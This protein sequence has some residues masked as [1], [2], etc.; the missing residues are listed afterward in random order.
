MDLIEAIRQRKSIRAFKPDPVSKEDIL[1]LISAAVAAPSKGNSQIWEFTVV[2]GDKKRE[3]DMML[4]DL[5]KTNPIPRMTLADSDN[6]G[7]NEM[8]RKVE[9]R[10]SR[11][12]AEIAKL[13]SPIGLSFEKFMLEGTFTFFNAPVAILIFMDEAFSKDLP[14]ILS[15]GASVQNILLAAMDKG[16]GT[17]WIGGVWRYTKE[18]RTLLDIPDNK[19]IVSGVALGYPDKDSLI[20]KYKSTRDK[21][22][23]FVRWVGI[24]D[25]E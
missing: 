8:L 4:L 18:L 19:R 17:C 22:I 14:H 5:L 9:K 15:V 13:L 21:P 1:S 10:A 6:D 20:N 23:E 7:K 2:T 16:L 25:T 3:M 24:D 12:E 11:N